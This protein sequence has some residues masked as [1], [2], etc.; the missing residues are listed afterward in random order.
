MEVVD[1][2]KCLQ[3]ISEE[4]GSMTKA[5]ML[6]GREEFWTASCPEEENYYVPS[7]EMKNYEAGTLKGSPG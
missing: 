6:S 1:C 7:A 4:A 5:A 2:V 3:S